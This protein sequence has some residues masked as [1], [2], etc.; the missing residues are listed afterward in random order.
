M[1]IRLLTSIIRCICCRRVCLVILVN[2]RLDQI[3][4][5]QE[6]FV[7][8]LPVVVAAL[9]VLVPKLFVL[10]HIFCG[11]QRSSCVYLLLIVLHLLLVDLWRSA[12]RILRSLSDIRDALDSCC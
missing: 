4:V 2:Q 3:A 12:N 7:L 10:K 9:I 6:V 1:I 8:G 11:I 5:S